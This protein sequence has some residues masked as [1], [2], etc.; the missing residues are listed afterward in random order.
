MEVT[1]DGRAQSPDRASLSEYKFPNILSEFIY[2]K[3]YPRWLDTER[4]RETWP[5]TV[6]RYITFL[7]VERPQ[8]P[9]EI[10]ASIHD[11]ILH[12]EV[13]PSMR[14]LWAAGE[15]ARRDNTTMYNCLGSETEFITIEGVR[16]FSD[17]EDGDRVQV[18]THTGAW[19]SA[20]VRSYGE[21]KLYEIDFAR[22]RTSR[23]VR[24]TRNH[25]WILSDGTRTTEISKKMQVIKPPSIVGSW[26]YEDS[27]PVARCYWAMGFV[28]GDGTCQKDSEGVY[29]YS[30]VRLCGAKK[31]RFL[32]RFREL[33]FSTSAPPSFGGD[34]VVYTRK[35]LKTLPTI[36]DD[37]YD[38]V[39]A[40]VR[41][42]LDADGHKNQNGGSSSPFDGIQ[43]SN[44]ESIQFI[45]E[46]FPAVGAY[47]TREVDLT[48]E[49]TDFGTRPQTSHFGLVLRFGD[50]KN[51]TFSVRDI[52]ES[53]VETVWCLEVED[54]HSFVLPCGL[55][56]GNCSFVPLDSLPSFSEALYILMCGTGVGFS[57]EK[58]FIDQLP[59]VAPISNK[60]RASYKVADS[61][62]GWAAAFLFGLRQWYSGRRVKFDCS[63][64]RKKGSILKTK[65]GRASGPEPLLK[66]FKFCEDTILAATGRRL[67]SIECHDIA[68]MIGAIVQV[69]GV[70]RSAMISFSDVDDVEMRHAKDWRLGQFPEAR[71][72]A[73]NSA[74]YKEKPSRE[75]FQAEWDALA[76][77]GSGE[78]G[79]SINNWHKR[80][81]RPVDDIR[82]NPCHEIGLRFLRALEA[83][84]GTGGSGS[85]CN[86]SAAVMRAWDD[87]ASMKRKVF[88]ATWIGVIQSSF[89]YF[90]YLRPGWEQVC[91][92][93]RLLGVDITGQCDNPDLSQSES[94]MT[95]FNQ[96]AVETARVA[97][98]IMGIGMPVAITCGKPSGNSSQL[99]DCSSGFHKR[100]SKFYIRRVRADAMDPLTQLMRDYG[101]PH[102]KENGQEHLPDEEV[103]TWVVEFPVKAPEKALTR[104]SETAIQMCERYL[105]VMRTWCSNY[106]HNQS[107]TISVRD[108]EWDALGDWV[109]EH[110]DEITGLSFLPY[111]GGSYRMAPYQEITEEQYEAL[112]AAMPNVNFSVLYRYEREDRGSGSS[113]LAC[114]NGACEI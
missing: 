46:V 2:T 69:G 99:L 83:W 102:H 71:Y 111:D 110:F 98:K 12:M 68:C 32:D 89:T 72:Q 23:T 48:G 90:P 30:M 10:L 97:S 93:D 4:R 77:S 26:Q 16:K 73:N 86:L 21:Q 96:V 85:F 45:R 43:S 31:N 95:A 109:F 113:E 105:Q 15:T 53:N 35:Y 66:L 76:K 13:L 50:S 87:E 36:E 61:T 51:S 3:T 14:A 55:V 40:F 17:F 52:R 74:F 20:V 60:R 42:Y 80:A 27:D 19:K 47:V 82:S 41:G 67:R 100:H 84:M 1:I 114:V 91:R 28:Y 104:D 107:A 8:I 94:A 57:V 112:A 63:L 106:G 37:G 62:E 6:D 101:V 33:G 56:T 58:T 59:V 103:T 79:F 25:Q 44:E 9:P 38:N 34:A 22:G 65:G 88:L 11:A 18:L 54:D 64:V 70:R 49:V 7:R 24:A 108:D 29:R 75:V 81:L 5:E 39:V 78:R 92:E